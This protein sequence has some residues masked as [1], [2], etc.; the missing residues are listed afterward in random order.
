MHGLLPTTILLTA[1]EQPTAAAEA[2]WHLTA[3]HSAC[4]LRI[5]VEGGLYGS[6]SECQAALELV[7]W[8]SGELGAP[9]HDVRCTE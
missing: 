2:R 8:V 5:T 7:R 6:R 1:I 4:S 9:L 3:L